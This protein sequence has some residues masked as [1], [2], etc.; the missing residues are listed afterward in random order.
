MKHIYKMALMMALVILALFCF[1][2]SASALSSVGMCGDDV[3]YTY[4]STTKELIIKGHGAMKDY[5]IDYEVGES[6]FLNTDICSVIIYD[7]VTTI[8]NYAFWGCDSLTNVTI[9]DSVTS[10]GAFAFA[11]CDSITNIIIPNSVTTIGD[12]A[13]KECTRL[14]N[15]AIPD[16]VISIGKRAFY[17]CDNFMNIIVDENNQHYSNDEYGVLFDKDKT[18]IIQYPIGNKKVTYSIPNS[19]TTIG[20]SAFAFCDSLTAITIPN[21]VT[22]IDKSAFSYCES[23][24]NVV[25]PD[26]VT[27]IGEDAFYYCENIRKLIIGNGVTVIGESAFED[28]TNLRSVNIGESVITIGISAFKDCT[29]LSNVSIGDSVTTISDSAFSYCSSLNNV[30]Y[31]GTQENWEMINFCSGNGCLIDAKIYYNY[32]CCFYHPKKESKPQQ[33]ATCTSIGYTAG[34]FCPDCNIWIE[35]HEEIPATNHPNRESRPQQNPSCTSVGYTEGICCV[36]CE[37]W[38]EGHE[39]IGF[40]YTDE[41]NN[42]VCDLCGG[43]AVELA[44][45]GTCWQNATYKLYVDGT[46][47]ISG[48]GSLDCASDIQESKWSKYNIKHVIIEEGISIICEWAFYWCDTIEI[49]ELPSSLERIGPKAFYW[50]FSLKDLYY[51]GDKE[52]WKKVIIDKMNSDLEE[53]SIHYNHC[54]HLNKVFYERVEPTCLVV[55]YT[56]GTHCLECG[57]WV[58]HEEIPVLHIDKDNA[59][60]LTKDGNICVNVGKTADALLAQASDG[61]TL[62]DKNGNALSADS[63]VGTGAVLT[64]ADGTE[65]VIIV[66]GDTDG[67]AAIT[68]ADARFALRYSVGLETLPADSVFVL[69]ADVDTAGVTA[70]DARSILRSAVGLDNPDAWFEKIYNNI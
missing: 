57:K 8:G 40:S 66:P 38:L 42:K 67:D 36:D 32:N 47:V 35:G 18:A 7:G 54:N 34:I 14:A 17:A 61:A 68:A 12:S 29:K 65:Y 62:V 19:V 45:I 43:Y 21:S 5:V 4:N 25:I 39:V 53:A 50:C 37:E 15:V 3:T 2:I 30:Y 44:E 23:L 59:I 1:V 24:I 48:E 52:Q 46:L 58:G 20:D 56:E 51:G 49:I 55:G 10:I 16:S 9:P 69:A 63:K 11:F 28:C 27:S 22:T 31:C 6:P 64:L 33:E 26:S 70:S 60:A 41:D 13:F